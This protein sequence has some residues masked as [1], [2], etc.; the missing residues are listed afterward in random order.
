M[1]T[2]LVYASVAGVKAMLEVYLKGQLGANQTDVGYA[3]LMIGAA[4]TVTS[5]TAG[6]VIYFF[7]LF[8][9]LP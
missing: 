1:D 9:S 8:N 5:V 4:F 3:F 2:T 6:L 7:L